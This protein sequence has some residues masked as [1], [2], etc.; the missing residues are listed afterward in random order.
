MLY[1]DELEV[2]DTP[3]LRFQSKV[4]LG[5]PLAR[6]INFP[7]SPLLLAALAI[8]GDLSMSGLSV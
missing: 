6:H 5:A 7:I 3:S 4:T 8:L 2:M 1:F